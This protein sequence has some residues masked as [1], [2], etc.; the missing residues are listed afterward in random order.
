MLGI[1]GVGSGGTEAGDRGRL[2]AAGPAP[3]GRQGAGD[4][5]EER[6]RQHGRVGR[7]GAEGRAGEGV[8]RGH[9]RG[10]DVA[11]SRSDGES[12]AAAGAGGGAAGERWGEERRERH[13][14]LEV[15]VGSDSGAARGRGGE[16]EEVLGVCEVW[17]EE[18]QGSERD[19]AVVRS[20]LGCGECGARGE[21]QRCPSARS[22]RFLWVSFVEDR[23]VF[24]GGRGVG[25][26]WRRDVDER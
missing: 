7:G 13:P 26:F 22:D 10:G 9:G 2:Q 12:A 16:R 6:R 11:V 23:L 14:V 3:D 8:P 24:R 25:V 19:G 1:P 18:E 15:P 17:T 5:G 4:H 20:G 21:A